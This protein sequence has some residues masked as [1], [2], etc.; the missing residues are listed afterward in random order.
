[1]STA[2]SCAIHARRNE[3]RPLGGCRWI[4][5]F[6][7][8][9][10]DGIVS[11]A[12]LYR[13]P[14]QIG[15]FRDR[16]LAAEAAIAAPLQTTKRHLRFVMDRGAVDVTDTR[17]DA[18]RD[19]QRSRDVAPEPGRRQAKLAVICHR[20]CFIV[21]CDALYRDHRS[22]RFFRVQLHLARDVIDDGWLHD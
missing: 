8:L 20:H 14:T 9:G 12:R 6:S 21:T 15:E 2:S 5:L 19:I 13:D 10:S 22:E 3:L 17:F 11:L 7:R 18:L 16:R 4:D 1:M